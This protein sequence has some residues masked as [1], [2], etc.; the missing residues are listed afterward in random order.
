MPKDL[1]SLDADGLT[2]DKPAMRGMSHAIAFFAFLIAGGALIRH[3]RDGVACTACIVYVASLATLFGISAA[4]HRGTWSERS[5]HLLRR[6][7]HAAIFGL[8]AGTYTPICLLSF[9]PELGGKLFIATWVAAAVGV[10]K[11]ILWPHAPRWITATIYVIVGCMVVPFV[12]IWLETA[13]PNVVA[14]ILIGGATY[15]AGAMTFAFKTPNPM[16]KVF[17]YHE[18]FHAL[19]V[20]AGGFH[21]WAVAIASDVVA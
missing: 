17:G 18:V 4:Y 21:F 11:A 12:P 3:V 14:L 15:I 7:D 13:D 19:V 8:I 1:F 5:M 10:M 6:L 2:F 9:P 20:A 16:P